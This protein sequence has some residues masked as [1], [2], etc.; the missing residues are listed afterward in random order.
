MVLLGCV[1][2]LAAGD[3]GTIKVLAGIPAIDRW[4]YPHNPTPG[5]RV[6]AS[7]FSFLPSTGVDDRFGQFIIKFDT[8]AA[9]VPA[10]LGVENYEIHRMSVSAVYASS[11]SLPYDPS[12]DPLGS[13]GPFATFEDPDLGRPLELHGTAFR[14]GF[15]AASFQ[16]NSAYGSRNAFAF[17]FDGLGVARDVSNHVT[18]GLP[19]EP[20]ALGRVLHGGVPLAAG[21]TIPMY[22]QV[23]FEINLGIP[24]V[25]DYVRQ[26]LHQGFI[27]FTLSS[28][29]P[30]SG[31][32]SGGFPAYFTKEHPEQAIYQDVA[33]RME[34]EYSLPLRVESFTRDSVGEVGITWNAVP[35][36]RYVVESCENPAVG[37]WL[38]LQVL[39]TLVPAS[40]HWSGTRSASREFFRIARSSLP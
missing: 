19:S 1:H 34:A 11:D 3:G 27:W 23:V 5:T 10:G 28:L 24:R 30:A 4:M 36:F 38:P 9:G 13:L 6:T 39:T 16:E 21:E 33:P 15:T 31:P 22:A 37:N 12:E 8:V 26:G 7:T 35:G 40:L 17:S 32:G 29:H 2:S 20:W 25:A 14:G 18:Q